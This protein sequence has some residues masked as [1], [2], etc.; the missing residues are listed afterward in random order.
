MLGAR[1]FV[2]F[3]WQVVSHQASA[4]ICFYDL[5]ICWKAL[6]AFH[7]T[8]G[9]SHH[10]PF[11]WS[12]YRAEGGMKMSPSLYTNFCV[13]S[14]SCMICASQQWSLHMLHTQQAGRSCKAWS[15]PYLLT[16]NLASLSGPNST[17]ARAQL[18]LS[19]IKQ[20]RSN[21]QTLH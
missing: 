17:G 10:H 5:K 15:F 11:H 2:C 13:I 7:F 8:H 14:K 16:Y 20:F 18:T 3:V 6:D 9:I 21:R 19:L 1:T 4:A 12:Q